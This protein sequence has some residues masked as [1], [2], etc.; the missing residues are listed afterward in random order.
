MATELTQYLDWNKPV[1]P[2]DDLAAELDALFDQIDFDVNELGAP[3]T[4]SDDATEISENPTDLNFGTALTVTDDGDGTVTF[5]VDGVS[6]ADLSFDPATQVELDG[7]TTDTTNPHSVDASQVGALVQADLDNHSVLTDVHHTRYAD[8]EAVS[9]VNAETSLTVDISGDAD[10]VDGKHASASGNTDQI[11][12]VRGTNDDINTSAVVNWNTTE[13]SDAPYTFDGANVTIEEAGM[14][15]IRADADFSDGTARAS[16][17]I[18]V[19]K[20]GNWVGVLGRTG[21]MRNADGHN[22]SSVHT[23]AV[24]DLVVGDVIRIYSNQNASGS[25]IVPNRSQFYIRKL[26]R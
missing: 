9:A 7:H 10:T 12:L 4:V 20:N 21:Y 24:L 14:Y 2:S 3:Q 6:V 25:N 1:F 15:D 18:G 8:T 11:L 19:Q 26:F 16:P 5:D 23:N 22:A 13:V 17:N